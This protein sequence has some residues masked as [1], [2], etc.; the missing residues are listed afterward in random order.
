MF[1]FDCYFL[2]LDFSKLGERQRL[3]TDG[4]VGLVTKFN[5]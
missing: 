5:G 3:Y 2:C 1:I 4:A